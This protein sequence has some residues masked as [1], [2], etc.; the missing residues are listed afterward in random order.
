METILLDD[1]FSDG[2]IQE[3]KFRAQ[4][5]T[6]DWESFRN[7]K[8]MIKGCAS[9][10]V[11]TWAYLIIASHLSNYAKNIYFGEPCAAIQIYNR[12]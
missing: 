4:I 9:V 6:I 7:K 11:P 5:K 12:K 10:P 8:V 1:F 2:M 3:K